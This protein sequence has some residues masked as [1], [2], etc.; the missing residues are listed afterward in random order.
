MT[1]LKTK[2]NVIPCDKDKLKLLEAYLIFTAFRH[3]RKLTCLGDEPWEM[4]I[5]YKKIDEWY[6]E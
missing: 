5:V 6:I 2:K 1:V 4:K 3:K